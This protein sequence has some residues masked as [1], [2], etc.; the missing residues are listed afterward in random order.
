M[1]IKIT[2][3]G[4]AALL[5]F[6]TSVQAFEGSVNAGRKYTDL[7]VGFG[8][9]SPGVFLAGDYLQSRNDQWLVG[10]TLGY[11]FE[12]DGLTIGPAV[13][14]V[15][16]EPRNGKSGS[17]KLLG[18]DASYAFNDM[19]GVY[20]SYYRSPSLPEKIKS[21]NAVR[22]EIEGGFSFSPMPLFNVRI[23]YQYLEIKGK[24]S[25]KNSIMAD[26]PYIG[27]SLLL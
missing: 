2:I 18:V 14:G 22:H 26:G 12:V 19:F 6:A 9:L 10:L 24:N 15:I 16:V 7:T 17:A 27:A 13:R 4:C 8:T 5:L 23:G 3:T 20:G 21:Y 25:G 1:K 11:R